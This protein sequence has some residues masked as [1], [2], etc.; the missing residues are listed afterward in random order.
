[1]S[2]ICTSKGGGLSKTNLLNEF[3]DYR[4][5][6]LMRIHRMISNHDTAEDIFQEACLRFLLSPAVFEYSQAGIKYF[7]LILRS[8]A[9]G[10]MRKRRWIEYRS[11]LPEVVCEPESDWERGVLLDRISKAV[12]GLPANDRQLLSMYFTPDLRLQD[13]SKA[14]NLPNSTMRYRAERAI[15]KVKKIVAREFRNSLFRSSLRA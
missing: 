2:E 12:V 14:L 5:F 7:C 3:C 1:V 11:N 6:F 10:Q 8:L 13:K 9:L 15:A 4:R